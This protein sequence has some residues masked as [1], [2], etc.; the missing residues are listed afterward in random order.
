MDSGEKTTGGW[1]RFA[2]GH[3]H[4]AASAFFFRLLIPVL[5]AAVLVAAILHFGMIQFGGF[6]GSALLQGAW[7]YYQGQAPYTEI[8]A[9]GVPP[10][11]LVFPGLAFHLFGVTWHSIVL[12][13]ALYAAATLLV[14]YAMLRRLRFGMPAAL[15]TAFAIQA[16][17][18]LP[19]SWWHYNQATAVAGALFVTASV[20]FLRER[21]LWSDI[22][23]VASTV[24]LSWM[25]I[26]VAGL[27]LA[28]VGIVM[29]C[30]CGRRWRY[31][32]CMTVAVAVSVA[33][34]C[35]ARV[36][37]PAL[38]HSLLEASGRVGSLRMLKMCL[39]TVD[40]DEAVTTLAVAAVLVASCGALLWRCRREILRDGEGRAVLAIAILSFIAGFAGMAT[41]LEHNMVDTPCVF[42]GVV[43]VFSLT[44]PAAALPW[45]TGTARMVVMVALCIGLLATLGVANAFS[46]NRI[47]S[48]GPGMFYEAGP[49]V[50]L[51]QPELFSG[52]QSSPRL[53]LDLRDI[54]SVLDALPPGIRQEGRVFFGPRMEF[55]YPAYG[56]TPPPGMSV[57]WMGTGEG[58][59]ETVHA[60][61]ETFRRWNPVCC[62]F[63]RDDFTYMPPELLRH[64]AENYVI[65]SGR[66]MTLLWLKTEPPPPFLSGASSGG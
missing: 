21:G 22:L 54:Q 62:I 6:D 38:I 53:A 40:A 27:L 29:L 50:A 20:L 55:G 25:K 64:L 23:F 8:I 42:T 44:R 63:L 41:N 52:L 49:T 33:A 46:R 48:I 61:V 35:A 66:D 1:L 39:W 51:S 4:G 24:L 28:G 10:S 34:M 12:M 26:N 9:P 31:L 11:Y 15:G 37:P 56:I 60:V 58:R 19:I 59:P 65:A 13:T 16:V 3:E 32:A 30:R 47:A 2:C 43:L 5:V 18:L 45:S 14:Q 57:W 36:S 7:R 17:S